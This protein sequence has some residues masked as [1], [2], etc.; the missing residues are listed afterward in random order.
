[1]PEQSI[2]ESLQAIK[3][4]VN[5]DG[6]ALSNLTIVSGK[7]AKCF[8]AISTGYTVLQVFGFVD[9][10]EQKI[11]NQLQ[12]I[13]KK[14]DE[15]FSILQENIKSLKSTVEWQKWDTEVFIP[16]Y[17]YYSLALQGLSS[18]QK[19]KEK[20]G[21]V[22]TVDDLPQDIQQWADRLINTNKKDAVQI[23]GLVENYLIHGFPSASGHVEI[24]DSAV[25]VYESSD[26]KPQSTYYFFQDYSFR[27]L[28]QYIMLVY[29][30]KLALKYKFDENINIDEF[31]ENKLK[32]LNG[33]IEKR[34]KILEK[35]S[36]QQ[37]NCI[38][39]TSGFNNNEYLKF[40]HGGNESEIMGFTF[41]PQIIPNISKY[42]NYV[43]V[44]MKLQR[45]KVLAGSRSTPLFPSLPGYVQMAELQ[46][47][48]GK[49]GPYLK[50]E[51]VHWLKYEWTDRVDE[52][53]K[54]VLA[55]IFLKRKSEP[56]NDDFE[57]EPGGFGYGENRQRGSD[58]RYFTNEATVPDESSLSENEI[59]VVIGAQIVRRN[60]RFVLITYSAP[61]DLSNPEKPV[62]RRGSGM[63]LK[64]NP[65][66]KEDN[67][68]G[69]YTSSSED[70]NVKYV[71]L[72]EVVP[73]IFS[74]LR[75][76][77]FCRRGNRISLA[78]RNDLP[79]HKI[80]SLKPTITSLKPTITVDFDVKRYN[81]DQ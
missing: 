43:V 21:E 17:E 4:A 80:P 48:I 12:E 63:A 25:R 76:A 64:S 58:L 41:Y 73:T 74:P 24:F 36:R 57:A 52:V 81:L 6:S 77:S 49:I 75:G 39:I 71:D 35:I 37:N 51:D 11:S 8:S 10:P 19:N 65:P 31:T 45:T 22:V 68:F 66:F 16:L 55:Q 18:F 27:L 67:Y 26:T 79:L 20:T 47:K 46:V 53:L 40:L 1:M 34:D 38:Y 54:D 15:R 32:K 5:A 60:N 44:G 13:E 9:S 29:G 69:A 3:V 30:C 61:L 2:E 7:L 42:N 56:K 23:L 59:S 28:K 70:D 50:I 72:Q 14:I 33:I 62:V 78:L